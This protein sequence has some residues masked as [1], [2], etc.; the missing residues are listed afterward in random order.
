MSS[1]LLN[2]V[3]QILHKARQEVLT[4]STDYL[5]YYKG[6]KREE[7]IMKISLGPRPCWL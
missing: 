1:Q 7:V 4:Q 2:Y 5:S 3:A 6:E